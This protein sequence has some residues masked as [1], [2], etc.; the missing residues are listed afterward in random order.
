MEPVRVVN[1]LRRR[2]LETKVLKTALGR[3]ECTRVDTEA[4]DYDT[5]DRVGLT[6]WS[7]DRGGVDGRD[8]NRTESRLSKWSA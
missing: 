7:G 8:V 1:P 6:D 5:S 2:R 4:R 3:G